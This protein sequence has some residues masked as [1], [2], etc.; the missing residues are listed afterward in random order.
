MSTSI[1]EPG[2]RL[3]N[4]YR[5]EDRVSES[6]GST[7]WKAIDEI[8]ARP[9]A[10]RTFE[11]DFA[12]VSDVVTAARS[13][14]RLTDPRLTQVFDADDSG[15]RAYVVSEWVVGDSLE[16]LLQHGPMEP[17]R[18]AALIYEAA[19]A[20]AAAH[21]ARLAHLRLTPANL[22]WTTGS[23]VKVTGLAVE[24]ALA[25]VNARRGGPHGAASDDLSSDLGGG[26]DDP[27]I[28]DTYGLGRLLYAAV[29]A[30]W[31]GDAQA[32]QTGQAGQT[33]QAPTAGSAGGAP[34]A[35]GRP[36]DVQL[37]DAPR[38]GG[39]ICAPSQV[40]AG[41]PHALDSVICRALGIPSRGGPPFA[42][43]ADFAAALDQVPRTPLPLFMG[44]RSAQAGP[45]ATAPSRPTRPPS[46]PSRTAAMPAPPL[47]ADRTS[48][49]NW[50]SASTA[51]SRRRPAAGDPP[52]TTA[53]R[54]RADGQINKPLVGLAA[55]VA[56]VVV[57][58]GGWQL[59][60]LGGGTA[61]TPSPTASP[62]AGKQ[63]SSLLVA[64]ASGFDPSP[65]D[66]DE[67][68]VR[69]H[70]AIDS[71]PATTWTTEGYNSARFG[72]LK[73]GVGL[74]L[75]MGKNVRVSDVKVTL[76]APAGSALQLR[77]GSAPTLNALHVVT[78]ATDTSGTITFHASSPIQ[79]RYLLL[80]FTKL[81]SDGNGQF[82]G[83]ISDVIVHR[84]AG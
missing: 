38:T 47:S 82:R 9:V 6:G 16:D 44:M 55:L 35:D 65:G 3:A 27:A 26:L 49:H 41:V 83:K 19:Q 31:P 5:L 1:I 40:L 17:E 29:T 59:S 24:A 79:G 53:P 2:A 50:S 15:E 78:K 57:A 51:P 62:S 12:W 45:P 75:D 37:P 11:P 80:W 68:S 30:H 13:A 43:P 72:Q 81:A 39:V 36:S 63:S 18:A 21:E 28:A 66:G 4:R 71:K 8:L 56:V 48:S 46:R 73:S 7:L 54:H 67:K 58:V 64:R 61:A 77:A 32:S 70:L 76:P 25:R 52:T 33:G 23:T 10:I 34:R 22:V 84:P 74:L 14:S 69:A 60:R 20:I 42:S